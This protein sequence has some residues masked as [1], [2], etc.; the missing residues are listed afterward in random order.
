M[1]I[2]NT[3]F[4]PH[5][6]LFR[7]ISGPSEPLSD[8]EFF[9]KSFFDRLWTLISIIRPSE[10]FG[11]CILSKNPLFSPNFTLFCSFLTLKLYHKR[12][13]YLL[14]RLTFIG[15]CQSCPFPSQ[16]QTEGRHTQ[17]LKAQSLSS[18]DLCN[19]GAPG[20]EIS[21]NPKGLA[22]L[23][24]VSPATPSHRSVSQTAH[25]EFLNS[26]ELAE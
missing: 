20:C 22:T 19:T 9:S 5:F 4:H 17:H 12:C 26:V 21:W 11:R 15:T 8:P 6:S 16:K 13:R 2:Q 18:T 7:H 14:S 3:P 24:K 23:A 25:C 10:T 1:D